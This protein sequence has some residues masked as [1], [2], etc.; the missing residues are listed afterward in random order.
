MKFIVK[1]LLDLL[2]M[3]PL[4]DGYKYFIKSI[5]KNFEYFKKILIYI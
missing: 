5:N 3:Q 2:D 4:C 1:N